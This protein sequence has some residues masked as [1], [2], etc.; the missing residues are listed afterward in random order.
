MK[1]MTGYGAHKSKNRQLEIEVHVKSVNGR[2]LEI[3]FH[4][5]KEYSPFENDFRKV[6][7]ATWVRGTV[8]VYIHRRPGAEVRLQTVKIRGENARHSLYPTLCRGGHSA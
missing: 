1:S 6:F 8:D 2:F 3:R 5:P 4:L 7:G